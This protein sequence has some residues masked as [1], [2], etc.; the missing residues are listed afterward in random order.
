MH[1]YHQQSV[2]PREMVWGREDLMG[3]RVIKSFQGLC[4][5]SAIR[6]GRC[7]PELSLCRR[8]YTVTLI[9]FHLLEK[10]TKGRG[11]FLCI[12]LS[13]MVFSRV[14]PW[15]FFCTLFKMP[16]P[17]LCLVLP[18]KPLLFLFIL[19]LKI[20]AGHIR[21]WQKPKTADLELILQKVW[22]I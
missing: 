17:L 6:K 12:L 5:S 15:V 21:E 1:A 10:E 13:Y 4:S 2:K 16:S 19:Y 7:G 11:I 9:S 3:G 8:D 22:A 14:F 18:F 20:C